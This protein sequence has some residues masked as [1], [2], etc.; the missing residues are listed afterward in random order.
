MLVKLLVTENKS[1][2]NPTPN[3]LVRVFVNGD[4]NYGYWVDESKLFDLL[5][6]DQRTFYATKESPSLDITKEVANEI[7]R[8]GLTPYS[9]KHS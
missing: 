5:S 1:N 8:I 4:Y 3:N 9:K 7:I 6:E 2:G